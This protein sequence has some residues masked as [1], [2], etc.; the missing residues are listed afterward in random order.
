MQII[1]IIKSSSFSLTLV[2]KD[3]LSLTV[4]NLFLVFLSQLLYSTCGWDWIRSHYAFYPSSPAFF[5][6][7]LQTRIYLQFEFYIYALRAVFVHRFI[8]TIFPPPACGFLT[9]HK[10]DHF[11]CQPASANPNRKT[12]VLLCLSVL[13]F[14]NYKTALNA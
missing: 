3:N 6:F 2:F 7:I 1:C 11:H 12:T 8:P 4:P 10:M 14:R 13:Y 9:L 5:E